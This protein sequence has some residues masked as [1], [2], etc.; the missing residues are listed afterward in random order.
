MI[1]QMIEAHDGDDLATVRLVAH[2]LKSS[3]ASVGA[4]KL[5]SLCAEIEGMI[6]SGHNGPYDAHV[7]AIRMEAD[8]VSLSLRSLLEAE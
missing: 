5:S 7:N 8:R 1:P 4:L 6:R 3:C 2:T